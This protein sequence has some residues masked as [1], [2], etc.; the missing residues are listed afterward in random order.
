MSEISVTG[1]GLNILI[2]C[3]YVRHHDWMTFAAWYS[4]LKNLPDAQVK[5]ICSRSD[6]REQFFNWPMKCKVPFVFYAG[7]GR[8]AAE[9]AINLGLFLENTFFQITP[10]I[11]AVSFYDAKSL[12]PV[13]VKSE[14]NSTFVSYFEGCGKFVSG[15]WINTHKNPFGL[16]GKLYSDDL[17][18]NEYRV[19]KLWE[20]CHRTYI[21]TA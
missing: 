7:D 6:I 11:M 1:E 14:E 3:D 19:L 8:P 5:I 21:A 17:S 2:S 16:A 12:G 10:E 15:E 20:K 18:L 13:S 9:H 4:I